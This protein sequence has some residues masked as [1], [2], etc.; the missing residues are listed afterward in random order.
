MTCSPRSLCSPLMQEVWLAALVMG[1]EFLEGILYSF[2]SVFS[3]CCCSP[4]RRAWHEEAL[5][6]ADTVGLV[7][8]K[9]FAWHAV[10]HVQ[11]HLAGMVPG[12]SW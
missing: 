8:C 10:G 2:H 1:S 12:M 4:H 7:A 5:C 6:S 3:H 9:A 11:P